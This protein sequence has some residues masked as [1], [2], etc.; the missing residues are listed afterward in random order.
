LVQPLTNTWFLRFVHSW[1]QQMF[2][3]SVRNTPNVFSLDY[4]LI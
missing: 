2:W 3:G 4:R 1:E